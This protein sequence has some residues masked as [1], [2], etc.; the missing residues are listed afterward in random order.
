MYSNYKC[1]ELKLHHDFFNACEIVQLFSVVFCVVRSSHKVCCRLF[2]NETPNKWQ[3]WKEGRALFMRGT[4]F[5]PP[6]FFA[7]FRDSNHAAQVTCILL[8]KRLYL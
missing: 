1:I 5:F 6:T 3:P 7:V 8:S 2:T 4:I